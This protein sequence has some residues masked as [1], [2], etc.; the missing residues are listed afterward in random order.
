MTP[1]L[2][3]TGPARPD[4][5]LVAM[6]DPTRWRMLNLVATH[7]EE[8]AATLAAQLP[9][10]RPAVAKHLTILSRAGLVGARRS[11]REVRYHVRPERLE[12]AAQWISRLASEWDARLAVIKRIAES[13]EDS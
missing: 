1:R 11:G 9:V 4:D 8:T 13:L 10:S 12:E 3:A 7:G 5:A 2:R 6:A